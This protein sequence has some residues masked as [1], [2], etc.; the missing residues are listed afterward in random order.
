MQFQSLKCV[1]LTTRFLNETVLK[2]KN[3]KLDQILNLNIVNHDNIDHCPINTLL[4][5]IKRS[6]YH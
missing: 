2:T 4:H 5:I 3:F 1:I 6:A